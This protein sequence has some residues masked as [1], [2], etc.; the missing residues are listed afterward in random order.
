MDEIHHRRGRIQ[1]PFDMFTD[2]AA[3][4]AALLKGAIPYRIDGDPSSEH[5]MWWLCHPSFQL[6]P[7]P[8]TY[9]EPPPWYRVAITSDEVCE[10]HQ[11]YVFEFI[12]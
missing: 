3:K 6:I 4:L 8:F 9:T 12:P 7:G 5:A 1:I 11:L 2:E 10:G